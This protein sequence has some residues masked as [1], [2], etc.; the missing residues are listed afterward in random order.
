MIGHEGKE[1]IGSLQYCA[2]NKSHCGKASMTG[3]EG[4]AVTGLVQYCAVNKSPY[5][6]ASMTGHEEKRDYRFAAVLCCK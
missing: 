2:I 6:K 5:G 4:K 3:H 1:V